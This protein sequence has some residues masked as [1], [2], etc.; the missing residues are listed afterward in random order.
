VLCK[1]IELNYPAMNLKLC[2]SVLVSLVSLDIFAQP[3][4]E[5]GSGKSPLY[6]G[7][8]PGDSTVW[9]R[10][11]IKGEYD[12]AV[13]ADVK[14]PFRVTENRGEKMIHNWL[15]IGGIR[16][17]HVFV[18]FGYYHFDTK[19]LNDIQAG[20]WQE[21]GSQQF[22]C[23]A[24]RMFFFRKIDKHKKEGIEVGIKIEKYNAIGYMVNVPCTTSKYYGLVGG[25]A[26][27]GTWNANGAKTVS[28]G[29]NTVYNIGNAYNVLVRAGIGRMRCRNVE[30]LAPMV[31]NGK[32]RVSRMSRVSVGV[33]GNPIHHLD[34]QLISGTANSAVE[35]RFLYKPV[36][37]YFCWEGRLAGKG[38]K[39]EFGLYSNLT[40]VAP[41]WN[42][43][44]E[45]PVAL[46]IGWGFYISLDANRPTSNRSD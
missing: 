39:R 9:T 24:E 46:A 19:G 35:Y 33:I 37:G 1:F 42:R 31:R 43:E 4:V 25:I 12:T 38:M 17:P 3:Q 34:A 22:Y 41:S 8:P 2:L 6:R 29:E 13:Y 15:C 10:E 18:G 26:Y 27:E 28:L 36:A 20:W 14:F 44:T 23:S 16:A 11:V 45:H 5:P 40:F 21:N 32:F 7:D 30:Y